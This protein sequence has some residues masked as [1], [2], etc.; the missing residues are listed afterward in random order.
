[1][2]RFPLSCLIIVPALLVTA[3]AAHANDAL[4]K[5]YAC[6]ACHQAERKVVGPSWKEVATRYADG[7]VTAAQ[8]AVVIK[9]GGAGKWGPM[10]MPA[11]SQLPEADAQALA[12][13]VLRGAK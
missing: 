7:S 4:A 5:K 1:M 12:A 2:T 8:L 10:A 3:G 9:K 6:T 13:W 11:Q